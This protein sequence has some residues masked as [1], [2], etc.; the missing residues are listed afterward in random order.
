MRT[1]NIKFSTSDKVFYVINHTFLFFCLLVVTFPLM[2]VVAQSLSSADA[3]ITGKVFLWP[4]DFSL[5]AYRRIITNADL[6]NGF[7]NLL[8]YTIVGTAVNVIL[9]VMAGYPLSKK[10]FYGRRVIIGAFVFTMMFSG[11]L[12]PSYLLVKAL[13]LYNTRWALIIPGAMSVWNVMIA[14]TFFQNTIPDELCES[15]EIDGAS[16]LKILLSIILPLSKP[17]IAV[18]TLFYA[19]DHWNSYFTGLIYLTKKELLP[20]QVV[21]RNILANAQ[22]MQEMANII[23]EEQTRTLALVEVLK[24]A[25]I[26]F[27][28]LPVLLL[29]PFIRIP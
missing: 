11:G 24:Y 5:E 15:A 23:D 29:Y 7:A 16:D 10:D 17:V 22:I 20:L 14:R 6:V 9:T 26:G 1:K 13:G 4:V 3:V 12:I 18:L 25:V 19:V 21:L 28:S 8:F 2:N 27:A